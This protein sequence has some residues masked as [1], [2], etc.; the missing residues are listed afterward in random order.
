MS[1]SDESETDERDPKSEVEFLEYWDAD[2]FF[3]Y[4][5]LLWFN[6]EDLLDLSD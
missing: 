6:M 2:L 1:I 4:F 5:F 3:L